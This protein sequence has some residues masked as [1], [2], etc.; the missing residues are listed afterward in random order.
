MGP[1]SSFFQVEQAPWRCL[2]YKRCAHAREGREGGRAGGGRYVRSPPQPVSVRWEFLPSGT[3]H[4]TVL[5]WARD[6][7]APQPLGQHDRGPEG[8]HEGSDTGTFG[9]WLQLE[10]RDSDGSIG[11]VGGLVGGGI[12]Y[13][14]PDPR[15]FIP[16]PPAPVESSMRSPAPA[17]DPASQAAAP[18]QPTR[19]RTPP[20]DRSVR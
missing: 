2:G 14:N 5:L 7:S 9:W 18:T 17:M 15:P 6:G 8:K 3:T 13:G 11:V 12:G 20:T 16:R 10:H 19:G 4:H 1:F